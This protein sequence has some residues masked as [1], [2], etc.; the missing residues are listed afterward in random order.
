MCSTAR[1]E[2]GS[3]VVLVLVSV[4]IEASLQDDGAPWARGCEGKCVR[5]VLG[6]LLC[7]DRYL[8]ERVEYEGLS[9]LDWQ[10]IGR[11]VDED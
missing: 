6:R 9:R 5:R 1:H 4:E 3:H 7:A 2:Y 10:R 11:R 8:V